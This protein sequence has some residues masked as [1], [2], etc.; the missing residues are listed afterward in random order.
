[1]TQLIEY[2]IKLSG[3]L[4]VLYL[5]YWLVLRRL[6]FYRWNRWYLTGYSVAAFFIPFININ[7]LIEK[8]RLENDFIQWVPV[9]DVSGLH[10]NIPVQESESLW[11]AELVVIL[12]LFG[13][14][15]MLIRFSVQ[16]FSMRAVRN[17]SDL[18][19]DGEVKVYHSTKNIMPFSFGKSIFINKDMH[20]ED[21][22]GAIIRHEFIHV[23]QRHTVD[24]LVSEWLCILNWYNP[25]AWLIRTAIRQ[26]LEFIADNKVLENGVDKKQYQYLLLK[27]VGG[28][29]YAIATSFNFASLKKR[30]AM[31]NK[32]RSAKL[33]LIK[34]LF[35]VPLLVV[36]LLAFRNKDDRQ[37]HK[38]ETFTGA[39]ISNDQPMKDILVQDTLPT[40]TK[41]QKN[42][43]NARV[44][45]PNK[46][47]YIITLADDQGESIVIIR[48]RRNKIVKAISAEEWEGNEKLYTNQYGQIPP[49]PPTPIEPP[50]T[51]APAAAPFSS[52]DISEINVKDNKLTI[53]LKDG[54]TEIF[55]L[56]KP[57]QK[58][59]FEKKFDSKKGM[60]NFKMRMRN[61]AMKVDTAGKVSL[62]T[63]GDFDGL[64]LVDD[65]EYDK[66][67]FDREVVLAPTDI[68]SVEVFKG[69]ATR[70][71]GEKGKKGVIR[72][73]TKQG[74][75]NSEQ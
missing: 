3:T 9:F 33:H 67:T 68:R 20:T 36:V 72:I 50:T 26:N 75:E 74:T 57:E 15:L 62:N 56:S 42:T 14:A 63:F 48:D 18:I 69:D 46:K 64:I 40:P 35:V 32:M 73:V 27:V 43:D 1:M 59:A 70:T 29:Q 22:L 60:E 53:V 34:F 7:P 6:T 61:D 10:G 51:P 24:I 52:D 71:F 16:Y 13:S 45:E 25:F 66:K 55:D 37:L 30:I 47:G 65:K 58:A 5:F 38:L 19:S 8:T 28:D 17:S 44:V 41:G 23:K 54:K 4:M 31:M 49:P 21:D 12:F 39:L 11:P 2:L